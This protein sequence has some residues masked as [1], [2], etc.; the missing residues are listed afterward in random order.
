MV[1][2][3][4]SNLGSDSALSQRG[5]GTSTF[6]VAQ[7]VGSPRQ[8]GRPVVSDPVRVLAFGETDFVINKHLSRG[9]IEARL[10][11]GC[12]GSLDWRLPGGWGV[13]PW[14][15]SLG[16]MLGPVA[17]EG[18]IRIARHAQIRR[19]EQ[20]RC[21]NARVLYM[22]L[23][24]FVM[25]IRDSFSIVKEVLDG[26]FVLHQAVLVSPLSIHVSFKLNRGVGM[27]RRMKK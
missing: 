12:V 1:G 9:P 20:Q 13:F 5:Q 11:C 10:R 8:L 22:V 3:Q 7:Q 16:Q 19:S 23:S 24:S 18:R 2:G 17:V 14:L 15:Q 25:A 6:A 21:R 27:K 26:G 4:V